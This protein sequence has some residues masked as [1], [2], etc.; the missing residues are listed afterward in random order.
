MSREYPCVYYDQQ[1]CTRDPQPGY[2]DWCVLGPC[3]HETPSRADRIRAMSD[4]GLVWLLNKMYCNEIDFCRRL[5]ECGR[6]L[7]SDDGIP[8]E[9]CADCL[10]LW[11]R[12]PEDEVLD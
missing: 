6:L 11:L 12:Q 4:E 7:E 3:S 10:L 1:K 2:T 9:K 8:E 5:E